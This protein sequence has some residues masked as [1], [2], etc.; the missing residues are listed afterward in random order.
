MEL[1]D[2][3]IPLYPDSQIQETQ[4]DDIPSG[5]DGSMDAPQDNVADFE[6]TPSQPPGSPGDGTN[7]ELTDRLDALIDILTPEEPVGSLTEDDATSPAGS[8]Y[9]DAASSSYD[10]YT[11]ELLES[12]NAALLDMKSDI[13]SYREQSVLY[14]EKA[15]AEYKHM[16]ET[17]EFGVIVLF[18]AGFFTAL[19]CGCRF[20]DTFFNRMR[21]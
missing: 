14:Q 3:Y 13:S 11:A 17:F 10:G 15:L 7:K 9:E 5:E 4:T 6:E 1:Y 8:V 21:G 12:M 20:A 16:S 19:S 18:A 2:T